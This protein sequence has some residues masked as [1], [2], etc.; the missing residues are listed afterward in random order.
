MKKKK[1]SG[2][3]IQRHYIYGLQTEKLMKI[4]TAT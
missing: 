4:K 1:Y 2:L 3:V